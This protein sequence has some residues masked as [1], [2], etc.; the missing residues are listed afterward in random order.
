MAAALLTG[1]LLVC[2]WQAGKRALE[3]PHHI[4][5]RLSLRDQPL[6]CLGI[7]LFTVLVITREGMET[8]IVMQTLLFQIGSAQAIGFAI[9]G[10]LLAAALAWTWSHYGPRLESELLFQVTVLFLLLFVAQTSTYG[11]H[12]LT[13]ASLLPASEALHWATEP[14]GPDGRYGEYFTYL[15]GLIPL[16]WLAISTFRSSRSRLRIGDAHSSSTRSIS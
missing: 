2:V 16:T 4:L 1:F 6:A 13:E 3:R 12:E 8:V 15:L 11:F 14:Y 7:F 5:E 9:A 10:T